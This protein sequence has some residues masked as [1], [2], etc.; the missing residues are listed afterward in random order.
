MDGGGGVKAENQLSIGD[1]TFHHT[2]SLYSKPPAGPE[3]TEAIELT[4]VEDE[5]QNYV[6]TPM[7]WEHIC[8]NMGVDWEETDF[9]LLTSHYYPAGPDGG[10][11]WLEQLFRWPLKE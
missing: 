8:T 9:K 2:N 11:E 5:P 7:A 3:L 1:C 6:F 4:F 10:G